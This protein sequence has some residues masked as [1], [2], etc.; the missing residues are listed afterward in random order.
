MSNALMIAAGGCTASTERCIIVNIVTDDFPLETSWT[1]KMGNTLIMNSPTYTDANKLYT[2]STCSSVGSVVYEINDSGANGIS[3]TPSTTFPNC[4]EVLYDTVKMA[5][6]PA[7]P[8][9]AY[10][11]YHFIL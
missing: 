10:P 6:G 2:T 3:C 1:L 9:S 11:K 8:F 4:Y 5:E 7:G